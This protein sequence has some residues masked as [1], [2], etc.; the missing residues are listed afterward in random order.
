[1][2]LCVPGHRS[3]AAIKGL[4]IRARKRHQQRSED[5]VSCP[6][7]HGQIQDIVTCYSSCMGPFE[8]IP[9]LGKRG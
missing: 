9:Q 1:M 6:F 3:V 4:L 8:V 5:G 7:S 2:Q